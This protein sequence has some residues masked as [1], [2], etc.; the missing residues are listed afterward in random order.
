MVGIVWKHILAIVHLLYESMVDVHWRGALG[1]YFGNAMYVRVT[2]VIMQVL[3]SSL[4][5]VKAPPVICYPV[6]SEGAT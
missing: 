4:K 3:E 5:K 2:H 6:F 1:F